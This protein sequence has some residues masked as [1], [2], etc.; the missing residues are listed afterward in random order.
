ML[1]IA[2]GTL[3]PCTV[4]DVTDCRVSK[5][6]HLPHHLDVG[7]V[8]A[9]S[10]H[11]D[12]RPES[13]GANGHNLCSVLL[14]RSKVVR[15]SHGEQRSSEKMGREGGGVRQHSIV[16]IK[17]RWC[18]HDVLH[19]MPLRQRYGVRTKLACVRDVQ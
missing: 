7:R 13:N 18:M 3:E 2:L 16:G 19:G 17:R 9:E 10:I 11:G 1:K 12:G 8:S 4:E 15:S 5:D 14:T 6:L